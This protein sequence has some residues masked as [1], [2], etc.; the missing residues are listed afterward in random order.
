[1]P[2]T[3]KDPQVG[4]APWSAFALFSCSDRLRRGPPSGASVH[5][6][7]AVRLIHHVDVGEPA[8][9]SP[10]SPLPLAPCHHYEGALR[11]DVDVAGFP[12]R[13]VPSPT[14]CQIKRKKKLRRKRLNQQTGSRAMFPMFFFRCWLP[15]NRRR[16][17]R[18]VLVYRCEITDTYNYYLRSRSRSKPVV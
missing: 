18:L 7:C 14:P 2:G 5:A 15:C 1:M 6:Q 10:T 9:T 16:L 3:H 17:S 11:V 8:P 12:S 4:L 13:L